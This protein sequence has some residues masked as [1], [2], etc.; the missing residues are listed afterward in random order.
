MGLPRAP[1]GW[2]GASALGI[3]HEAI[4]SFEVGE[5]VKRISRTSGLVEEV[6]RHYIAIT[7]GI[8]VGSKQAAVNVHCQSQCLSCSEIFGAISYVA[9][10]FFEIF[11][12]FFFSGTI[13]IKSYR[14]SILC[15]SDMHST[16]LSLLDKECS[17]SCPS[18]D[19]AQYVSPLET[20]WSFFSHKQED[21]AWQ[22]DTSGISKR[23]T[24]IS[25][26]NYRV[27][28]L[29]KT[30][31]LRFTNRIMSLFMGHNLTT[32]ES[33]CSFCTVGSDTKPPSNGLEPAHSSPTAWE[34]GTMMELQPWNR[35]V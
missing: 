4:D 7:K 35:T 9:K 6:C 14:G 1:Y 32:V 23:L 21:F 22:I 29:P 26:S 12:S 33:P 15:G 10:P 3:L 30:F 18:F 17:S 8:V 11:F 25:I 31:K 27:A 20:P 2:V 34:T 24:R 19:S 13:T 5:T 16:L 28:F